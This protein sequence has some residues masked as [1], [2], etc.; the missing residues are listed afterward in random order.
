MWHDLWAAL[1]LVLV[2]EGILPFASPGSVR[3]AL[4]AMNELTDGQLRGAGLASMLLGLL[5]LYFVNR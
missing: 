2:L 1:A 5:L 3:R 4:Q